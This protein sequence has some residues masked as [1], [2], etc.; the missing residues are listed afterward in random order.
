MLETDTEVPYGT[1][2]TYD[3]QTPVKPDDDQ[4]TYT[5]KS[6]NPAVS[7][8]EEDTVYTAEFEATVKGYHVYIHD[9]VTDGDGG[10][11]LYAMLPN[12]EDFVEGEYAELSFS[13]YCD[14]PV[15]VGWSYDLEGK[16]DW[17]TLDRLFCAENEDG[18]YEFTFGE[19]TEDIHIYLVLKGDADLNG[20]VDYADD[21]LVQRS[22][23]SE[24]NQNYYEMEMLE[25]FAS[26][27]DG[28]FELD[29]ADD[30]ALQKSLLS[31]FNK[32]YEPLYW[33]IEEED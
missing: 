25:W 17:D 3:G 16:P 11:E 23:L 30:I 33:D 31:E 4:Y 26:D 32:N 9:Y 19:L 12:G 10:Y 15:A 22:L 24:F 13:L 1:V 21:I 27:I 5:F 20:E 6:W 18:D 14:L 29:Y 2:P 8:V 28:N 7:E